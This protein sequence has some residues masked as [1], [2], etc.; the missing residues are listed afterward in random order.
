[1]LKAL[2]LLRVEL[3]WKMLERMKPYKA[4]MLRLDTMVL[5]VTKMKTRS[6]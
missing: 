5:M 2:G 4:K 3:M 6:S 1:V